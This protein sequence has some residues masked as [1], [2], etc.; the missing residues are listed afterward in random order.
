M[1]RTCSSRLH[2]GWILFAVALATVT[3]IASDGQKASGQS[4]VPLLGDPINTDAGYVSGTMIGD[5]GKEVRIYRG[6]PYAAP[7]VGE[8]R[9]KPPQQAT[10]WAGIRECVNFSPV[11]TQY[12]PSAHW[13]GH[14][15]DS[16]MSE[17]C[18]HLNL[19]TPA[20]TANDKLPVM[21]WLHGGGV[22]SG[23]PNVSTYNLPYLPQH[24][25]VVV[26][27]S[28]RIGVMGLLAHPGLA[29]ESPHHSSGQYEMLDIIAALQWVQRNI[30]AFGG[31]PDRVTI[32]GQSGGGSKV[33]YLLVSPLAKGLFQRAIVEAGG[34]AGIFTREEAQKQGEMF[35]AQ[36]SARTVAELRA[37]PWQEIVKA[38]PIPVMPELAPSG[39]VQI[40]D[41]YKMHLSV[42]GWALPDQPMNILNQSKRNDV[43]VL[44]GGGENE[45]QL[46]SNLASWAPALTKSSSPV[47]IYRFTHV[48]SNWKKAGMIAYHGLEINYHFGDIGMIAHDNG[49]MW[50]GQPG[51]PPD[52]GI[53]DNDR[54]VA[55]NTM[56][57]WVQFAATG[58]PSVDGLIKWPA[59]KPVSGQDAYV[60]IDV[61][62]EAKTRFLETF[63]PNS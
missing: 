43:P 31:D 20:I 25:V 1:S 29:A 9:W 52:P 2:C 7:A 47:F 33:A 27:V 11:A 62:P 56:R 18:L 60:N 10:P 53:D 35:A 49:A 36:F 17:N 57:M 28:H 44:I 54:M 13:N 21:V 4:S 40:S 32:F 37:R 26:N 58:D 45:A 16:G 46:F 30:A 8:L 39:T 55:E 19:L 42:D 6:I 59:F 50:I 61:K 15:A 23:N 14:I 41:R 5:V 63:K 22:D 12:F 51:L 38:L 34:F 24:G 3:F 48:P